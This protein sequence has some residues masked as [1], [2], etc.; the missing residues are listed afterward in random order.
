MVVGDEIKRFAFGLQRDRRPH[1]SKVIADVEGTAGLDTGK[2]SHAFFLSHVE[3]SRDISNYLFG[4]SVQPMSRDSS[5]SL[6]MTTGLVEGTARVDAG[7][8]AH[9]SK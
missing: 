8:N 6:K 4:C 3:R 2:D 7:Q 5:T 9:G 1:H